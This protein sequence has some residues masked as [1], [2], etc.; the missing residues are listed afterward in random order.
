MLKR[1]LNII[2]GTAI[3]LFVL[4]LTVGMAM[5][6]GKPLSRW[7]LQAAFD[8]AFNYSAGSFADY[9][10][11][12]E[13]RLRASRIDEPSDE[14][15]TNLKPFELIPESDCPTDDNGRYRNGIVLV[16][17][18][19]AS[20][21][22]MRHI[23]EWFHSRCFY[24]MG[25][26]LTGHG[27]RPGDML[28]ATWEDW[29]ADVDFA[30]GQLAGK[31]DRL[32]LSGH[33][34]G[35]T[36][37]VLEA[38]QNPDVD[39]LILF[40]PAMGIA[41]AS[42]Y[43]IWLSRLGRFFPAAAWFELEPEEATYRYESLPFS[44][45]AQTWELIQATQN[46]LASRPLTLPVITVASAQDTTVDVQS[47]L[48]FMQSLENPL[49][50]TLLYAQHD[51]PPYYN[52]Q[53]VNSNL[54]ADG[55]ISLGHLGLMTPPDHPHYGMNGAY[56]YCGQ[57]YDEEID[58]FERCKAGERDFYGEATEENRGYGLIERIAF[59]PFYDDMLAEIL[60]FLDQLSL[61]TRG[62]PLPPTLPGAN[63]FDIDN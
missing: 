18:L 63:P 28:P 44:A 46:S 36:L 35:G 57:Y 52:T 12:S 30:T 16:H 26:L 53:V 50:H 20:P 3:A 42:Q 13:R 2:A 59:N 45:A 1:L 21:W 5:S 11:W 10:A 60:L 39:A 56:R 22:S 58:S 62:L 40:A 54:P 48:D 19:I 55:I 37:S 17:G 43:A 25:V 38:G 61:D 47:T 9:I 7:H 4:I 29:L 14:I 6:M 27:T 41:P 8:E 51:L 34:V 33:S 32:F 24:V 15:I 49:S 23:G 31:V